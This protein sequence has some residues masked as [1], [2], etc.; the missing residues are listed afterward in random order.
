[1]EIGFYIDI[2][3]VLIAS[4]I[5]LHGAYTDWRYRYVLSI[6]WYP[7]AI[8]GI[9]LTVM[10]VRFYN[11]IN[12]VGLIF[13]LLFIVLV[14]MIL[15]YTESGKGD[16]KAIIALFFLFPIQPTF[17]PIPFFSPNELLAANGL[18]PFI[19]I[20]IENTAFVSILYIFINIYKNRSTKEKMCIQHLLSVKK[21]INDIHSTTYGWLKTEN[22]R[23]YLE[24]LKKLSE[25][26]NIELSKIIKYCSYGK[27]KVWIETGIPLVSLLFIG[28][29]ISLILGVSPIDMFYKL[30]LKF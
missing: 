1:M 22:H 17:L 10:E 5:F 3:R 6:L 24:D 30:L 19:F 2:T 23:I 16:Y 25:Q 18:R 21:D 8:V 27:N 9:F 28:L 14:F 29:I 20:I 12:T 7:A 26:E 15:F 4:L 11:R 13:G